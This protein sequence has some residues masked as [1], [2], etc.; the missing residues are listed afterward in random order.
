M[1]DSALQ[2]QQSKRLDLEARLLNP[3][4]KLFLGSYAQEKRLKPSRKLK[5][6]FYQATDLKS[7]VLGDFSTIAK[8][9]VVPYVI[10]NS[11]YGSAEHNEAVGS[12]SV[13]R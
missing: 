2:I 1:V 9:D 13:Q 4:E 11:R 5:S 8:V 12:I 6:S 10:K 3:F 7:S